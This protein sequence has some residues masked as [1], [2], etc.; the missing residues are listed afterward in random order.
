MMRQCAWC[1]CLINSR[2]ERI[3]PSPHPKLYEASH[4]ICSVCGTLWLMQAIETS[5]ITNIPY[6]TEENCH[7]AHTLGGN[8]DVDSEEQEELFTQLTLQLQQSWPKQFRIP[9][10]QHHSRII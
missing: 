9:K 5:N 10:E 2:G 1:L 4:G 7:Q 8:S 6:T 3:S